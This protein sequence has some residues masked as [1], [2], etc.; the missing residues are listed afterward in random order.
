M[1][2]LSFINEE[3]ARIVDKFGEGDDFYIYCMEKKT[4]I[5]CTISTHK[6]E[7][8]RHIKK[9]NQ[10]KKENCETAKKI[11][12]S[13]IYSTFFFQR[14]TFFMKRSWLKI[15]FFGARNISCGT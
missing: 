12:C 6:E 3:H 15:Y 2:S 4:S 9:S 7:L 10:K 14:K 8:A 13:V 11:A 5:G 1:R